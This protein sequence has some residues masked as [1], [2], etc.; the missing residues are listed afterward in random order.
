MIFGFIRIVSLNLEIRRKP[1][2]TGLAK[3][4]FRKGISVTGQKYATGGLH[5]MST[6][7]ASSGPTGERSPSRTA[8]TSHR[9][10]ATKGPDEEAQSLHLH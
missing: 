2:R 5:D 8:E 4:I 6:R 1:E 3:A 7:W 9:C 10:H